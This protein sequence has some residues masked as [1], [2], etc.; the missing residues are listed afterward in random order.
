MQPRRTLSLAVALAFVG[1]IPGSP[2]RA[3][4]IDSNLAVSAATQANGGGCYPVSILPSL[5]DMLTLVNPE[6]APVDVGAHL[7]PVSDPLTIHGTVD[8]A[9]IN[10]GG[11]FPADH[12]AVDENTFITVDPAEMDL[13]ATGNVGAEGVEAGSLEVEWEVGRYPLFAWPGTGDRFTGVGRWIWDCGH[14]DPDPEGTCSTTTSEACSIDTDCAAP[15]C[16]SCVAG[17]TCVGVNF[18][19]HSEL[20]PPQAVAISRM[21]Q[22]YSP[23]GENGGPRLAT[24]TDVWISPD[25]GGA[26]DRCV[27]THQADPFSLL[28]IDCFPLSQPLA[29]VNASNFAFDIP[30]PPRPPHSKRPVVRVYDRTPWGLPRPAV[31]TTFVDGPTPVVHAEVEMTTPIDGVLPSRVG[32]TIIARWPADHTPLRRVEVDVTSLEIVN[33]LKPVT[34]LIPA[35][36]RCSASAQDC[37]ASACPAGESCLTLG[38]PIPGWQLYLEVNGDWRKVRGLGDVSSSSTIPQHLHYETALPAD[39]TLHLHATGKSLG[40]SEGQLY[41]RSLFKD[42]AL[43]GLSDGAT[44]LADTSP[45]IGSLDVTFR[46]PDFGGGRH[47]KS[48]VTSSI[49]GDGGHCSGNVDQLCLTAAD[50]AA[51]ESCVVTGAAYKLHYT[52]TVR[53]PR[54][55]GRS[56]C[57]RSSHCSPW[58]R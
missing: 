1:A 23:S 32:K 4:N 22:G 41:G 51:A 44:C 16:P 13:V 12:V 38:G 11:D 57:E 40:C 42:L 37:S 5:F 34:P 10:E 56:R 8:L 7:P 58:Q 25:G 49:G 21:G 54:L 17:E 43:Y 50:C 46:G 52:I 39:G 36:Q 14:P 35:R 31:T 45:D 33:P 2:T 26:G 28:G 9:K 53:G 27:L 6:W 20:H 47:S 30:L 29:D 24:R 55:G 48:Y 19:Y 3:A 18:N 15:V